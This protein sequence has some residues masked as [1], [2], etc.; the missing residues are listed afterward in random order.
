MCEADERAV[1]GVDRARD[2]LVN[3]DVPGGV[4]DVARLVDLGE[5][6]RRDP[7]GVGGGPQ[8]IVV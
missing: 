4:L 6:V 8:D 5:V 3:T 2:A 1:A 7:E